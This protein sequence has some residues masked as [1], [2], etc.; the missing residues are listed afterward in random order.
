[1]SALQLALAVRSTAH[2]AGQGYSDRHQATV[3]GNVAQGA[4]PF[5]NGVLA[6]RDVV[7]VAH[8]LP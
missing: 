4:R 3:R 2:R 7:K 5:A 6:G 1:M 8:Q